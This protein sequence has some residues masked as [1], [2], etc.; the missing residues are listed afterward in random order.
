MPETRY[1]AP[2]VV[3]QGPGRPAQ[4]GH[5]GRFQ[6]GAPG[7]GACQVEMTEKAKDLFQS[8]GHDG[9]GGDAG[10]L[11]PRRTHSLHH[12]R[13]RCGPSRLAGGSHRGR[14]LPDH[15]RDTRTGGVAQAEARRQ[16]RARADHRDDKGGRV[17]GQTASDIRNDIEQT[18]S[19]M[20]ATIE[21]IG[22][23]DG[24]ARPHALPLLAHRARRER[25]AR[26][27]KRCERRQR[28]QRRR[29]DFR[30]RR[31]GEFDAPLCAERLTGHG[32]GRRRASQRRRTYGPD[33]PI[34]EQGESRGHDDRGGRPTEP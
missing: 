31:E 25:G 5:G 13:H 34:R 8:L 10:V 3:R 27:Q 16:A 15:G 14:G 12:P 4:G 11:R 18:R 6:A 19:R 9:R 21:A 30:G 24:R 33:R 26:R 17:V 22:Y 28:R 29:P 23:R 1:R 7:G 32:R 20:G 2:R